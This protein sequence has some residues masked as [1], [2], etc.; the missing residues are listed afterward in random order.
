MLCFQAVAVQLLLSHS[1]DPGIPDVHGLFPIHIAAQVGCMGCIDVLCQSSP[2]QSML[3][4]AE[5]GHTPLHCLSSPEVSD[6][7]TPF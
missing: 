4:E 7:F 1:A 5:R 3:K 2:Q 6:C